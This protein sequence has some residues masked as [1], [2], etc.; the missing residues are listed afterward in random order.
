M[1]SASEASTATTRTR[2]SGPGPRGRSCTNLTTTT[3]SCSAKQPGR[4]SKP[5][6]GTNSRSGRHP[7]PLDRRA[8]HRRRRVSIPRCALR[9]DRPK[10]DFREVILD[11]DCRTDRRYLE[12]RASSYAERAQLNWASEVT[13]CLRSLTLTTPFRRENGWR[14]PPDP[15]TCHT[16]GSV[17]GAR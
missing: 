4:N 6:M 12:I 11:G 10:Q 7:A 15:D 16:P 17:H 13:V 5:A 3:S 14:Y 9:S 8:G 2:P 1:A